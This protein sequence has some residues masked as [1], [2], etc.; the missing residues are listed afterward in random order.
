MKLTLSYIFDSVHEDHL[1]NSFY[2]TWEDVTPQSRNRKRDTASLLLGAKQLEP[3]MSKWW[4]DKSI[5]VDEP[6]ARLEHFLRDLTPMV[7]DLHL[8]RLDARSL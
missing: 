3:L 4:F 6:R 7:Y 8:N 2:T 1:P 5:N